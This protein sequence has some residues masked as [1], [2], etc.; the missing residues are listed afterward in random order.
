MISAKILDPTVAYIYSVQIRTL[1]LDQL[2]YKDDLVS[3][4]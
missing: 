2:D 1:H 4:V 3:G